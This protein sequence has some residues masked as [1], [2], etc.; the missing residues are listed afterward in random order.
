M[1]SDIDRILKIELEV[2][3]DERR[4]SD[5]RM[6]EAVEKAVA[7]GAYAVADTLLDGSVAG[8]RHRVS[9]DYRHA[10]FGEEEFK[11]LDQFEWSADYAAA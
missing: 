4:L 8:I 7:A 11:P 2:K 3:L 1:P 5:G 9:Y 6:R 10:E